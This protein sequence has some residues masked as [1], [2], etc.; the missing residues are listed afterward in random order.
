LGAIG[1]AVA[2]GLIGNQFGRGNG[3]TGMTVLGAAGGGYAG[4]SVER[5]LRSGTD[6][7]VRVRMADGK[8]RYF[9]YRKPPPYRSGERVRIDRGQLVGIR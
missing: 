3:R 4:N 8:I 7:R 5:R 1:G 9:T 6:Y 2:G